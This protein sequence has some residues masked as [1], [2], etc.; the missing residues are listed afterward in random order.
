MRAIRRD[1]TVLGY[2][3]SDLTDEEIQAGVLRFSELIEA[4]KLPTR[5]V[6]NALMTLSDALNARKE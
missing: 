5:D 2:D 1:M 6:V 3:L 4:A